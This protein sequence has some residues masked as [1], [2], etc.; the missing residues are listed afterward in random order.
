MAL[1]TAAEAVA[2]TGG[3]SAVAWEA[4]GVSIDTRSLRPGDLFVALKDLRDGHEFVAQA[5][6]AGAAAALGRL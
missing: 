2:A 1:W 4:Q 3:Q 5:L 6:A